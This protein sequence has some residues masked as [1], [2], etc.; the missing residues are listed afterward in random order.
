M[1]AAA[2][3]VPPLK[4]LSAGVALVALATAFL[5][6]FW[7]QL[8]ALALL[9]MLLRDLLL[10]GSV[11]LGRLNAL[12]GLVALT[13]VVLVKLVATVAMFEAL[14]PG[15]PALGAAQAAS[16]SAADAATRE[17]RRGLAGFMG[18]VAL[19]LVPFFA[20]Y[21]AWGFLGDAVRDYSKLSLSVAPFGG[22][23]LLNVSGG[24]WL[25]ASVA[26]IWA[27]RRAAKALKARTG[28]AGWDVA[29]VVCEA[30][31]AFIG[32]YV[33]SGWKDEATAFAAGLP[34]LLL[35]LWDGLWPGAAAAAAAIPPPVEA[36]G[37]DLAQEARGLFFYAL[38][39]LVWLTLAAIVYGYD[40]HGAETPKDGRVARLIGRLE[41]APRAVRDFV[42]HF[43]AGTWKRYRAI[44]NGVRLTLG[45]GVTLAVGVVV[46]WRLIDWLSAWAWLGAARLIGPHGLDLWQVIASGVSL[47][48]GAPSQPGDG[49]LVQPL[50][51]C[52]LAAALELAF[53]S[54]RAFR[55]RV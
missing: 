20:V 11:A 30:A 24:A 16:I 14:R 52:L 23:M 26:A 53:A 29:I 45:A 12:A 49:A 8:L 33:I 34:E 42:G 3:A 43:V 36:A 44:A 27:V 1:T 37:P 21:A 5:R 39:P 13:S 54:G 17:E 31:W 38:Y 35:R 47:A 48:L 9:D 25:V 10:E 4:P 28:K 41:R 18:G 2:D 7:P 6:R 19:A 22:G 50:K 40:V 55:R 46:I 51:I 32:L 15:L